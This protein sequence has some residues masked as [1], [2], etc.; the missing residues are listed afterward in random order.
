[1]NDNAIENS[2]PYEDDLE[3]WYWVYFGYS[4]KNKCA[5]TYVQ[6]YDRVLSY[7]FEMPAK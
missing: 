6:F 4:Q 3:S 1:M 2:F 5:F 7:K